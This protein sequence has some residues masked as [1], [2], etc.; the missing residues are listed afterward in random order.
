MARK[1]RVYS[2]T[3]CPYCI[4]E[5]HYLKSKG[6][7]FEEILLDRQ[8]EK[9]QEFIDRC[10]NMGVPCTHIMHEDGKEDHILGFDKHRIDE[11]LGL[12]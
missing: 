2:T 6:V 10:G 9:V 3:T 1:V 12:A 5:K 7:E 4:M 11:A 8:P